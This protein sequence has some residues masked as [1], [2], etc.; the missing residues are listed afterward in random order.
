MGFVWTFALGASFLAPRSWRTSEAGL[1]RIA[2]ETKAADIWVTPTLVVLDY[3]VRQKGDEF[4]ALIERSDMRYL[5]PD[6][7]NQ[8][9][10]NNEFRSP[11]LIAPM[12]SAIWQ[13]WRDLMSRL[14]A[15]LHEAHVPLLAASD[16]VGAHGVL[17]GSSLHE[18]LS[19]FVRAGMTPYQ[20]IRTATVNPA[21]YLDAAQEFGRVVTGLRGDLVLLASNPLD[22]IGNISSRVGVMKRGRWFPAEEL[23]AALAQMAD[24][25]N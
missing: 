24:E 10:H 6:T 13:S 17:P 18:E 2:R 15:K 25:R 22:D 19:L 23:E 9:I 21:I 14:V 3:I 7:R 12:Q 11:D 4:D 1:T 16:S 20:A 5:R 8:W